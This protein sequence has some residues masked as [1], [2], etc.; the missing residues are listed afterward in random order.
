VPLFPDF[1]R[2][3]PPDELVPD[4]STIWIL[5]HARGILV[6]A[7]GSN[8]V[9]PRGE[10]PAGVTYELNSPIPLGRLGNADYVLAEV[11]RDLA[12]ADGLETV[13]LRGL[14]GRVPEVEWFIAGYA[15]QVAHWR[16]TSGFCP[17]CGSSMG[18]LGAE[19][20]RRCTRCNHERYPMVSPAVLALVHDGDDRILLAHK[21][22][23]G[24]RRSILA[25]FVLPGESLEECVHREVLEEAGVRVTDVVYYGSQPWPFPHQLMV[26]FFSRYVSGEIVIDAEELEG[27]EWHD[28]RELP[29][30][31][32]PLSLS[33]Q[34][35]DAWAESRR[36]PI[37]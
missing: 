5:L 29:P 10:T 2:I 21:P 37:I 27:A 28:F 3:Y 13:D 6:Q 30:L 33:R 1:N 20:R 18:P 22:G 16:R 9:L 12:I 23:W 4:K 17:I 35:I 14:Y 11:D 32:P 19:W 24:S 7:K 26:G 15:S 31:P 8:V 36:R 34:M 25:G